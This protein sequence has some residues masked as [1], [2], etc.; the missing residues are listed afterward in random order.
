MSHLSH[1]LR[2]CALRGAN[3]KDVAESAGLRRMA[4]RVEHAAELHVGGSCERLRHELE[5]PST[6][7]DAKSR[8]L[9][10]HEVGAGR[11]A[12]ARAASVRPIATHVT[13]LGPVIF[14]MH[15]LDH[16]MVQLG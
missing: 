1:I 16:S 2:C 12:S 8:E 15:A 7:V 5:N 14:L 9:H 13:R 11:F 3:A 4:V 6:S 10:E